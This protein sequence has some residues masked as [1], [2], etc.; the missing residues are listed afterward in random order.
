V[1]AVYYDREVTELVR[2]GVRSR[3]LARHISST[4]RKQREKT[5]SGARL[6][7]IS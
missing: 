7:K 5:G 2:E 6:K 3:R 4:L 1:N